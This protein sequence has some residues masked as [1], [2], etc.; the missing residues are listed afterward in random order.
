MNG[1]AP[2]RPHADHARAPTARA[3]KTF[4]F[5]ALV[6]AAWVLATWLLEKRVGLLARFDPVD[7]SLY[8]LIANVTVGT[9]LASAAL[10]PAQPWRARPIL[11]AALGV[12]GTIGVSRLVPTASREPVILL[13]A[14]AQVLPTSIA[15][16]V[17]CWLAVGGAV[18]NA[19]RPLGEWTATV[20]AIVAADVAFAA[21]HVAHS[22]PFDEP[23]M[24][25]FLALPGLVVSVL[26]F[27][28]RDRAIAILAQNL[29]AMIG[30]TKSVDPEVFRR[31][32]VWA[33]ALAALAVTAAVLALRAAD[34]RTSP[35]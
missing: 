26:V 10:G 33:Y 4:V 19:T 25:A 12:L 23:R 31:P 17:V 13:N 30:V 8:A 29:F 2:A 9:L 27:V 21:Y 16:V 24:I 11:F 20:M 22:P 28:L 3:G 14:F 1:S 32:F 7:R 35:G 15:E 5:A 18:R 6:Y 34:R